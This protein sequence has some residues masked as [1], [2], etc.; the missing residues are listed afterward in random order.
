MISS[1]QFPSSTRFSA[2]A[3]CRCF[4]SFAE[5]LPLMLLLLRLLIEDFA[6]SL[7]ARAYRVISLFRNSSLL[8]I[9]VRE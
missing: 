4:F 3:A 9:S 8:I 2:A 6:G 1:F 7:L 5:L